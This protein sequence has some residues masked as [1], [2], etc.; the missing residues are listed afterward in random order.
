MEMLPLAN[1]NETGERD[2]SNH[3]PATFFAQAEGSE[4]VLFGHD[5]KKNYKLD[6]YPTDLFLFFFSKMLQ[7]SIK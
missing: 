4:T 3:I 2:V 7:I 6:V 5:T 1:S